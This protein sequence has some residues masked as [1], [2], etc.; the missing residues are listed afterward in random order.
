MLFIFVLLF[1][2]FS[3]AERGG[4]S[5]T[6]A[7]DCN[8]NG[9]CSNSVCQC[10]PAWTGS[11]CGVLNL[12]SAPTTGGMNAVNWSEWGGSPL[13][14]SGTYYLF[15]ARMDNHCG[16]NSWETNSAC[17]Q[18]TSTSAVG[19]YDY[20]TTLIKAF[21]HNPTIHKAP[22]GTYVLYHIGDGTTTSEITNCT[23]GTTPTSPGTGA[24][25]GYMTLAYSSSPTGPFTPLGSAIL[26]GRSGQWDSMVTNPAAWIFPNGTVLLVYRGK[27]SNNTE[28]LGIASAPTWK[29]PYTRLS[30]DPI[31]V[32]AG[33][34]DP[35]VWE[36]TDGT[37]HILFNDKWESSTGVGGHAYSEDGLHWTFANTKAY[38]TTVKWTNGT[39][40]TMHR[41]ERPQVF[42]DSNMNPTVLF[43]GVQPSSS[44]DHTF[45]LANPITLN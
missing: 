24:G 19:P 8:L 10:K 32:C 1:L 28:L 40:S 14:V 16:L 12:A 7:T 3:Q 45:T 39:S 18:G 27:S 30:N 41:R 5:C 29:G 9:K 31:F 23:N 35:Y 11:D 26:T 43:N 15:D 42:F 37:F 25:S 2:D 44:D 21:C 4:A 13:L 20:K 22:D 38:T 17:V 36:D 33:A 6:K 34:E